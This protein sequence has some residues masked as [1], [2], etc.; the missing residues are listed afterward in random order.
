[1]AKGIGFA[2]SASGNVTTL[3]VN[4]GVLDYTG[5]N[6]GLGG[7]QTV[8]MTGGTIQSNGGVSSGTAGGYYRFNNAGSD[9]TIYTLASSAS[10]VLA[11]RA[12]FSNSGAF[13]VADGS[14][15]ADLLVS[16][17]LTGNGGI[18]YKSGAGLLLLSGSG[19]FTGGTDI[20]AG[21]VQLGNANGLGANSN[22]LTVDGGTLDLAG[23]SPTVR[24]A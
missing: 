4:G 23:L 3:T 1:M 22:N 17:A 13:N 5:T 6:G 8:F 16:A 10:A 9:N 2:N 15:A 20:Q 19:T 24:V 18:M 14:A 7:G 11:G 21:T 12:E